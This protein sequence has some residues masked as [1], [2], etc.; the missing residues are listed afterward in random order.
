MKA[1]QI[2]KPRTTEDLVVIYDHIYRAQKRRVDGKNLGLYGSETTRDP[3]FIEFVSKNLPIGSTVLDA[4]CGRGHLAR[5][6]LKLGYTVE[7]TEISKYL[8]VTD[9]ADLKAHN[10]TYDEIGSLGRRFDAVI[11]N[12]VLEHLINWRMVDQ[13]LSALASLSKKFLLISVGGGSFAT[14]DKWPRS[15]HLN[16]RDLHLIRKRFAN[17]VEM[18]KSHMDILEATNGPR[19]FYFFGRVKK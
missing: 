12:D 10:L 4:S 2:D 19:T 3:R 13:S 9:L 11:S 5:S 18:M 7:V 17:W 16:F 6:L 14:A 8:M 15:L 1:T